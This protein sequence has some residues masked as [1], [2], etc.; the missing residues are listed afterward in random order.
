MLAIYLCEYSCGPRLSRLTCSL[1]WLVNCHYCIDNPRGQLLWFNLLIRSCLWIG[2]FGQVGVGVGHVGGES[3]HNRHAQ[4]HPLWGR[5]PSK[6]LQRTKKELGRLTLTIRACVYR[7]TLFSMIRNSYSM[8]MRSK[9]HF[10][11]LGANLE[12]FCK[13]LTTGNLRFRSD[14]DGQ[15]QNITIWSVAI[16]K[17]LTTG[18]LRFRSD[19]DGQQQNITIWSVAMVTKWRMWFWIIYCL[20][21][22]SLICSMSQAIQSFQFWL[23][24]LWRLKLNIYKI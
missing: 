7:P 22:N 15:Q 19:G 10:R 4:T 21:T 23:V 9:P 6:S 3:Q 1:L 12:N 24:G 11:L 18:N 14:G 8:L 2:G 17:W 20:T 5:R 16:C 13:W